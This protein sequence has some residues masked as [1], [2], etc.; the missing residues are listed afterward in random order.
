VDAHLTEWLNLALRWIHVITGVAWIGTSFYFNWLNSRIAPPPPERRERGVA[1]ELWSVHGG[2]L[3]RVVKYTVAPER[4]P[5]TLHWFKWEAYATWLSGFA[6]LVL[7]YYLGATVYLVDPRGASIGA[8]AAIAVGVGTLVAAWLVYDALCRSPLG[9]APVAL[10]TTLFV[11]GAALAWGLTR[12]LAA[13]A[14][15]V[16]VGAAIGTIMAAN[17]FRV[18]IPSQRDM[19]AALAEGRA[20]D[21]TLGEQAALRSL[22]NNYFTLPVLFIMVSGHY[23]VTYGQRLS[24]LILA[25]LAMVGVATRHWFN[26]RN[27]GRQSPWLLPGAAL[28]M[29]GLG[30]VTAP[31][32]AAQP[33]AP[34]SAGVSFAEVRVVIARRC[35]ACHS[36]APTFPGLPAAPAGVLLDTPEQIRSQAQR[37]QTVAVTAHTMP[38]GNVTGMT[39]DERELLS[40]W[41]R[42]GAKLKD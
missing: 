19:V 33:S 23:P 7:V 14:S 41:I 38:L 37:I 40:R 17:V 26:L 21:S 12:L 20:P 16:H 24:W 25:G 28:G 36:E 31:K 18:I 30:F 3:Y 4:L 15:Y 8:G 27:Q 22:H 9:K 6:L 5:P 10:T 42:E 1:G 13:R 32:R 11:L 35:A 2:G 34:A 39:E 29:I